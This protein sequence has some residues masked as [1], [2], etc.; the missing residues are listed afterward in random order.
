MRSITVRR[1][2]PAVLTVLVTVSIPSAAPAACAG[3]NRSP[4]EIGATAVRTATLCLV[5][6]KRRAHDLRPLRH[7]TKLSGRRGGTR[8]TWSGTTTS[9]TTRARATFR[10]RIART[11]WMRG[12]KNW[13]IGENLAWG[14]GSRSTPRATVAAWMDSPGHRANILH[15]RFRVIGIGVANGVPVQGGGSGATYTTDFGS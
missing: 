11:G 6:A 15:G 14:G 5:N 4:D 1:L 12:R 10:T 8:T 9:R 7:A 2:V 3:R 13:V